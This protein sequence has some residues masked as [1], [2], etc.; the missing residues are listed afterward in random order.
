MDSKNQIRIVLEAE[1]I[2]LLLSLCESDEFEFLAS[3]PLIYEASQNPNIMRKE[4]ALGILNQAKEIIQI[5]NEI[6]SRAR[7]FREAGIKPL[8]AL[9]LASAEYG[10]ADYFCTC[11]DLLLTKGKSIK[12]L[13]TYI[14]SPIELSEKIEK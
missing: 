1:A 5:N 14:V 9:H 13:K 7:E 2:L 12:N 8:D 4:Y 3:E 10:K 6:V 11:D